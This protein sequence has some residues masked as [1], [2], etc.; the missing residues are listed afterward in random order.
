[1]ENRYENGKIYTI[2]SPNTDKY[3]I[4][5]TCNTLSKRYY[6]HIKRNQRN[7]RIDNCTAW[8]ITKL[9]DSYIELLENYPC[10]SR[11]ELTKRENEL[12][13]ENKDKV[14]NKAGTG[15]RRKFYEMKEK[16]LNESPT[17]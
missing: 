5:S 3:Y 2:R 1:M 12:I 8:E 6:Q 13:R 7:S 15:H 9:G 11:L 4:G 14:V 10:K 17:D 16:C